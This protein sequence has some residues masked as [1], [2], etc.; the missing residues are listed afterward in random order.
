MNIELR[1]MNPEPELE[2]EPGTWN[3]EPN[4]NCIC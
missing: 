1:T 2:H 3:P 4:R